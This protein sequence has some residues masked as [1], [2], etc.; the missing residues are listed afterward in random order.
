MSLWDDYKDE[1]FLYED[2]FENWLASTDTWKTLD[3]RIIKFIDMSIGHLENVKAMLNRR[4]FPIPLK[5]NQ[6]LKDKNT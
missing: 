6:A 1:Q 2:A 4:G 3:G 5:L